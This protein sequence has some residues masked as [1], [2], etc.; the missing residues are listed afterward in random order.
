MKTYAGGWNSYEFVWLGLFCDM[1]VAL[2]VITRDTLFGFTVF[3]TGVLCV[4][5]AAKGNLMTYV[6]GMW[7]RCCPASG[8]SAIFSATK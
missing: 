1:A 2:T 8:P 3:I 4:V 5:L 6:F 7:M